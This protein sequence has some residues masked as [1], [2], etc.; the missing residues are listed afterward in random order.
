MQLEVLIC[1]LKEKKQGDVSGSGSWWVVV[2]SQSHSMNELYFPH[3]LQPYFLSHIQ[4]YFLLAPDLHMNNTG[5]KIVLASDFF[6]GPV[7]ET[8]PAKAGDTGSIPGPGRFHELQGQ[9]RP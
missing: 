4:S 1:V 2:N 7:I 5:D 6:G 9:P 3:L 8:P